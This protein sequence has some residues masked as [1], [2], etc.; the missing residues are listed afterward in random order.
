[1]LR[2]KDASG[3]FDEKFTNE[4]ANRCDALGIS[5]AFKDEWIERQNMLREKPYALGRTELGRLIAASGGQINGTTL[6]IPTTGYHTA[7]ETASLSSIKA[8]IG[9]LS[10][11][12][13]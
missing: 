2:R 8:A 5:H 13:R 12:I 10:T 6:Q 11:F 1:M 3:V 4:I 7:E 9:L